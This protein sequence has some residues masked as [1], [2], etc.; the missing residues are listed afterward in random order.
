MI[1]ILWPALLTDAPRLFPSPLYET[2]KALH[3]TMVEHLPQ[4][5]DSLLFPGAALA[6]LSTFARI[7]EDF[8]AAEYSSGFYVNQIGAQRGSEPFAPGDETALAQMTDE[9]QE[10]VR[11]TWETQY[12]SMDAPYVHASLVQPLALNAGRLMLAVVMAGFYLRVDMEEAYDLLKS[13]QIH[14]PQML[15]EEVWY[16][17][18]RSLAEAAEEDWKSLCNTHRVVVPGLPVSGP[19]REHTHSS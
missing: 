4:I 10:R 13:R 14:R 7:R 1:P 17:Y 12:H 19:A 15:C 11:H 9:L 8:A 16:V 6:N 5:I 18:G 2:E 3:E